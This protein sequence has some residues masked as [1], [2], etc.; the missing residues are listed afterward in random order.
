[1]D[2]QK[3]LS[4]QEA[5]F[6]KQKEDSVNTVG[7]MQK[8]MDRSAG[9]LVTVE[10]TQSTRPHAG[11]KMKTSSWLQNVKGILVFTCGHGLCDNAIVGRQ[12]WKI[13]WQ[14][15]SHFV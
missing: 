12:G 3:R 14:N 15:I 1:M 6:I 4:A 11:L 13:Y 2:T 8:D 5:Q 7:I 10:S 9:V